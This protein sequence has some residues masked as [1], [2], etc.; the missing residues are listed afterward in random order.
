MSQPSK[1]ESLRGSESCA[2]SVAAS[3]RGVN[4][5]PPEA[6]PHHRW[7]AFVV[8]LLLALAVWAVFGQT[9]WFK[10]VNYDDDISVYENPA[11]TGG[12]NLHGIQWVFTHDFAPDEW[13]PVTAISSML[14]W[15]IYGPNAGG[16]HLTN[17]LLHTAN[18]VLLFL[19]LRKMTGALWRSAFVAAVFAV[20]P[21]RVESVAWVTE[22]KDVLSG[23]FFMLTLWMWVRYAQKRSRVENPEANAGSAIS[24]RNPRYWTRDTCLALVIFTL[25]L[26][27]KPMLV[28]LPLVLLLL[29]YWPLNRLSSA[30]SGA[31]H[32]CWRVR[33]DLVLEKAPFLL[34]S[35]AAC[36]ATILSQSGVVS[37]VQ[38]LTIPWRIG[39]ALLAYCDYLG[40]LVYPVGLSLL[41]P[42]P[43]KHLSVWRV[44]LS[45]LALIIITVGVVT[46]RRKHPYLPVGWLWYLVM[47]LPVI[48]AMQAGD[49]TRADRYT[50]LPQIGLYILVAWGAV[51][52]CGSWPY[53]RV[54]L[55]AAAAAILAA[56]SVDA[57][58]QTAYWKNSVSLWTRTLAYLPRSS[59]AQCNLG[60][61]LADQGELDAAIQRF[62]H[63]L[64]MDPDNHKAIFLV[65]IPRDS[66][67]FQP[68]GEVTQ[69]VTKKKKSRKRA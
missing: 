31:S 23:S 49:Q 46:G 19:L 35:A 32:S 10:F 28:T 16:H 9:L 62:Q 58:L 38:G 30:V 24:P 36:A 11:V 42:H 41:Y 66:Q 37:S 63:V 27:S 17:V 18:V 68:S 65:R 15:Q 29:D 26:L 22:R 64:Q 5:S 7:L 57:Y 60:I 44:G 67:I 54:A 3:N 39:N 45:A 4:P 25:G 20:H 55:G 40:H 8:C 6:K 33:L 52:V 2:P 1:Y 61:A 56:F 69:T 53:R 12:L 59:V 48:G 51:E 13:Y 43:E 21:L 47:F 14:D 34:L 50:Y